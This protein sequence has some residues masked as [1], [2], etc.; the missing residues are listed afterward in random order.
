MPFKLEVGLQANILLEQQVHLTSG[1]S[2]DSLLTVEGRLGSRLERS[3]RQSTGRSGRL[4]VVLTRSTG[5]QVKAEK[6]EL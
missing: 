1:S 2:G 4:K 5:A 6:M 3:T